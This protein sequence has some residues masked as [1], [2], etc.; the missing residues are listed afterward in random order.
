MYWIIICVTLSVSETATIHTQCTTAVFSQVKKKK[1]L[2]KIWFEDLWL[3]GYFALGFYMWLHSW[4]KMT[5]RLFYESLDSRWYLSRECA[6]V[7]VCVWR[8]HACRAIMG[9]CA[10]KVSHISP[11]ATPTLSLVLASQR[12]RRIQSGNVTFI[13]IDMTQTASITQLDLFFNTEKA[14]ALLPVFPSVEG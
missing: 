12:W 11:W 1:S 13:Q 7:R 6:C 4:G 10:C 2:L 8:M 5:K 14:I 9:V 3:N